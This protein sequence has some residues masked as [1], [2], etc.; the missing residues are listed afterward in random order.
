MGSGYAGP[1]LKS[2]KSSYEIYVYNTLTNSWNPPI[3]IDYCWF[4]MATLNN[5]LL[6]VGGKNRVGGKATDQIFKMDT[7]GQLEFYTKMNTARSW[8]TAFSHEDMLLVVGGKDVN[9]TALSSIELFDSRNE[10]WYLCNNL[11]SPHYLLSAVIVNNNLYL[12]GGIDQNNGCSPKVFVASL[13]TLSTRHELK[14]RAH[15]D[16]PYHCSAAVCVDGTHL[17]LLGGS[18]NHHHEYTSDVYRLD[19]GSETW[20]KIGNLPFVR[21]LL[22]PVVMDD[23]S[24]IVIGG[25]K[26]KG[27]PAN[28]MWKGSYSHPQ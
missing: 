19:Q 8:T 9:G 10:E 5:R 1:D 23:G 26:N 20:V 12:L 24:I 28:T 13:D 16:T 27:I 22:A 18:R 11:P 14:W 17:L 7:T 3:S 2:R 25:T 15:K 4:A 6:I 21:N